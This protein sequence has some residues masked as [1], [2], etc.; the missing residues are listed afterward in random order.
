[1]QNRNLRI[2]IAAVLIAIALFFSIWNDLVMKELMLII[3]FAFGISM[4]SFL[5]VGKIFG[6][7]NAFNLSGGFALFG[8]VLLLYF[9]Y[10][11]RLF[12]FSETNREVVQIRN[13]GDISIWEKPAGKLKFFN[14][15]FAY[16]ASS[17][18][19]TKLKWF[20]DPAF[21][22]SI[23]MFD[24][25][26][27]ALHKSKFIPRLKNLRVFLNSLNANNINL[28]NVEV[29]VYTGIN[30]PS[31]SFFITDRSIDKKSYSIMY[32]TKQIKPTDCLVSE[33]QTF[34]RLLENE[35]S[36]FWEHETTRGLSIEKLLDKTINNSAIEKF[37]SD[38][39]L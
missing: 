3:L 25:Q 21:E 26:D 32:M 7:Y 4:L 39:E 33:S 30:I 37:Y 19:R 5:V 13:P 31:T 2:I 14:A 10:S 24:S 1:M 36:N 29:K 12:K 23:L 15:P 27:S 6:K 16:A 34:E 20:E 11:S 9:Q 18:F 22:L 38:E 28:N 17:H 8:L 35:F